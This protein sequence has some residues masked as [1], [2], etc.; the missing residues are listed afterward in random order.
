M[1][2]EAGL[3]SHITQTTGYPCEYLTEQKP[4]LLAFESLPMVFVDTTMIKKTD[5]FGSGRTTYDDQLYAEDHLQIIEVHFVCAIEDKADIWK[6]IGSA[7]AGWHE[8]PLE[9]VFTGLTYIE[10]GVIGRE[11]G[12][13]WWADRWAIEFPRT[14][15]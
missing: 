11:N 12:R 8:D 15:L 6:T 2:N 9:G 4:S 13:V 3:I 10:G 7:I 1:Y 14:F 5:S